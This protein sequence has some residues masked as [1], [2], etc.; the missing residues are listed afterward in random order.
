MYA[1]F[2]IWSFE[3]YTLKLDLIWGIKVC[4]PLLLPPL[5]F[6]YLKALI[7]GF[8]WWWAYSW[9]IFFL[10]WRVQ[11]NFFLL[12]STAIDLQEAK[13]SI[14]EEY[15][16]LASSTWS[17]IMWYQE[18]LHLGDV[19]LLP[20]SFCSVNLLQFLV[21][22]LLLHVSPPLSWGLVMFRVDSKK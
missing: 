18:H 6:S 2:Q 17:Y 20:L 14:D 19:L 3:N 9:L 16:R 7:H 21:L 13:D 22:H 8:L 11:S 15:S 5:I 12:H 1:F 4:A 10:K